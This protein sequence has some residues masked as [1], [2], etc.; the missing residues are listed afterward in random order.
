MKPWAIIIITTLVALLAGGGVFSWTKIISLTEKI[1]ELERNYT[2]LQSNYGSLDANFKQLQSNYNSLISN[3][4][5]L[6]SNY[7]QLKSDHDDLDSKYKLLESD[8]ESLQLDYDKLEE[9]VS[10]L[11][12]SNSQLEAENKALKNTVDQQKRIIDQYEKVP[13]SYYSAG[14]FALHSNTL[15]EL[16]KFLTLEFVLPR[17]YQLNIFDCSESSAY[18]EWAL[19]NAGFVAKIAVGRTPWNPASGYHTWVVAFPQGY[20]VAIEGTALTGEFNLLYL[21]AGRVPG[22]IFK[23][24]PLIPNWRNY[25]EGYESLFQNIYQAIRDRGSASEWNWWEGFWGFG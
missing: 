2:V 11:W 22:V 17:N 9:R 23:D 8:Y 6:D 25:Y 13:H 14:G 4:N 20:Q 10:A 24:D 7:K 18:L 16:F 19:E 15:D 21:L 1:Y 12:I 5:S 3:Y